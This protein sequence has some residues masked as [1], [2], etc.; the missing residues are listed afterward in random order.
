MGLFSPKATKGSFVLRDIIYQITGTSLHA[1]YQNLGLVLF[2]KLE[3][4]ADREKVE[5]EMRHIHLYHNNGF[6]THAPSFEA[7][8][9]QQFIWT[10]EYNDQ[11]EEAGTLCVQEHECVR[12]G[13]IEIL[14]VENNELTIKWSGLADVGWNRKYGENVPFET[15]F[16][17]KIPQ[18]IPYTLDAIQSTKTQLDEHTLLEIL[19]LPEFNQEVSRVSESCQ[20]EDFNTILKFRVTRNG[21]DYLGEVCFKNGKNNFELHMDEKCPIKLSFRYVDFNLK[22]RYEQFSF[23][24][25]S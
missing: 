20:W 10:S 15:I 5:Y 24:I 22:A 16:S 3:A 8:K 4:K 9:G 2:P 25:L 14:D 18:R 1:S 11:N 19:N 17:V 6:Q 12:K 23:E 7:L 21:T 13:T